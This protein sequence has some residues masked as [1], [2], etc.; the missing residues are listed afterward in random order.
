MRVF[1]SAK[2]DGPYRD[3]ANRS[4]IL[5][6]YEKNFGPSCSTRGMNIFGAYTDWG[7]QTVGDYGERSQGHNSIIDAADGRTYLIYHT[8]FQNRG[9]AFEV[10]VHQVFQNKDGWL[11][12]APFEYTGETVTNNDIATRQVVRSSY[13]P[14]TYHLLVHRYGLDHRKKEAVTPVDIALKYDGTVEG[15]YTG[16]W[17][18]EPGTSYITIKLGTTTYKGVV[19]EQKLEPSDDIA[20][21]FT[22]TASNG[23]SIWGQQVEGTATGISDMDK[24]EL[25][26][27]RDNIENETL[28]DLTGRRISPIHHNQTPNIKNGLYI[29]NGRKIMVK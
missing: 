4:A 24:T 23:V 18:L 19:V 1:R 2:P 10:R 8:R 13:L 16:T 20:V 22:A 15:A 21:C 12:A 28:Y 11:C 3:G 29:R 17:Q 7:K 26:E 14:A 25:T 5:T 6:A 9:E 27:V